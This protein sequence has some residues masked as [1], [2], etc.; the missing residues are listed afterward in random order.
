MLREA[1]AKVSAWRAL[2]HVVPRLSVNLSIKQIE[3]GDMIGLIA[4]VLAET[5]L[6]ADCLEMELTES[7]I[8]KDEEVIR[9]SLIHI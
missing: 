1:C 5:G 6:P 3:R 8:A 7:F 9:L 2:G 4:S